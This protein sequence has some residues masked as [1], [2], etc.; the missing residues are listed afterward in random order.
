MSPP[1]P[2]R[3]CAGAHVLV[4]EVY[5]DVTGDTSLPAAARGEGFITTSSLTKSYGLSSLRAGWVI[6]ARDVTYRVRRARDV[7]DGTGSIVA[8]RLATLA[9]EHLDRLAARGRQILA[10]NKAIADAFL[11]SRKDL[12]WVPSAGAIVFPRIRGIA[13]AGAFVERL[14]RDRGTA[15]GPGVFFDAPAHFRLGYGGDTEKI[16]EGL[17]R[18]TAAL[19]EELAPNR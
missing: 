18:L 4:D 16:R 10:R 8:E 17:L 2:S 6:A 5:R 13:D 11:Q 15:V 14:M 7:V 19:N 9:F 1:Y 3:K 12:E